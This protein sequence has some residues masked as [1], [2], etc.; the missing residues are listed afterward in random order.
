MLVIDTR[1]LT[2]G[3]HDFSFDPAAES[4]DLDPARFQSVRVSAQIQVGRDRIVVELAT[5][6]LATLTCDRTLK[7]FDQEI[8]G[9]YVA[10]CVDAEEVPSTDDDV[11]PLADGRLDLTDVVRDT[12][13]LSVPTRCVAPDSVDIEIPTRFGV[14]DDDADPRWEALRKL[15]ADT[16]RPQGD[17]N[18]TSE[19]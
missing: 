11:L 9:S 7:E 15:S 13:L 12:V 14:S 16:D 5:T 10:L 17:S 3:V 4:L 18:I 8:R 2:P 19:Q 6:A 1:W